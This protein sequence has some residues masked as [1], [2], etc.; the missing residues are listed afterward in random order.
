MKGLCYITQS[1]QYI[2]GLLDRARRARPV[3]GRQANI[4]IVDNVQKVKK[5]LFPQEINKKRLL[6]PS[7][8][9]IFNLLFF[10][11]PKSNKIFPVL[12]TQPPFFLNFYF[13]PSLNSESNSSKYN[14]LKYFIDIEISSEY[15]IDIEIFSDVQRFEL[16]YENYS[17]ISAGRKLIRKV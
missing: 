8:E 2:F 9:S 16:N 17:Y 3:K 11:Y 5:I 10:I 13:S 6:S 7:L 15:S 4:V 12:I 1:E 14:F